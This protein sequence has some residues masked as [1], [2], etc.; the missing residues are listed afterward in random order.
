LSSK[1]SEF[2]DTNCKPTSLSIPS[3]DKVKVLFEDFITVDFFSLEV[4]F[5]EL[6]FKGF[7]GGTVF[8]LSEG[9]GQDN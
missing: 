5:T 3:I 6:D 7:K 4:Y 9:R 8:G 2:V 1:I